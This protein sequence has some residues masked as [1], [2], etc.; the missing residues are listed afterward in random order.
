MKTLTTLALAL[1]CINASAS[2]P[3]AIELPVEHIYSPSGFHDHEETEVIISGHLPNLC[4]QS[5]KT[6]VRVKGKT[7]E[8]KVTALHY[9][10]GN[11]FCA[12]VLV[13]F[14]ETVQVGV[15][16]KGDYKIVVN[17]KSVFT[18]KSAITVEERDFDAIDDI[19][20]ANVYQI[21]KMGM[22]ET[23]L[24]KGYNPSDCFV[25]DKIDYKHNGKDTYSIYPKMKQISDFCPRKLVPFV[26]KYEVPKDLSFPKV[27][28]HVKAMDGRSINTLFSKEIELE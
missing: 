27:L 16:D 12:N 4:H 26:Y 21:E 17:P 18:K 25:L 3:V 11:P 23:I 1:F 6:E 24:L 9:E 8:I 14:I 28:L 19:V 22:T 10:P 7:I 5:P 15:L 13:P 20:F 2:T